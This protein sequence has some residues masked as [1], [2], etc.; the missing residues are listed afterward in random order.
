L[1][2]GDRVKIKSEQDI[3]AGLD[4]G[5]RYRELLF[6]RGDMVYWCGRIGILSHYRSK[7]KNG[8]IWGLKKSSW[9]W[10]E[11]WLEMADFFSDKDFD[12][13]N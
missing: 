1:K 10:H 5:S 7:G 13:W 8:T 9:W 6:D 2:I 11:D 4:G 12:I 3:S